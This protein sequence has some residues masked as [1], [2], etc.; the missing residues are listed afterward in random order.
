MG[1][2]GA[3]HRQSISTSP[4]V[5]SF[6]P[7]FL[8]SLLPSFLSVPSLLPSFLP[9]CLPALLLTFLP[10][11]LPRSTH[12]QPT[13]SSW[14]RRAAGQLFSHYQRGRLLVLFLLGVQ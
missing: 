7:T 5:K 6:T 14:P 8:P 9:L 13:Q 3:H 4:T 12:H 2:G 10:S 1:A 11:G